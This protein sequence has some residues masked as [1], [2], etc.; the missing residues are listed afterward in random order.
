MGCDG[1]FENLSNKELFEAALATFEN[2]TPLTIYTPKPVFNTTYRASEV[3]TQMGIIVDSI[4]RSC[5]KTI[6]SDNLSLILICFPNFKKLHESISLESAAQKLKYTKNENIFTYSH[7]ES[8]KG[9]I[10]LPKK[11]GKSISIQINNPSLNLNNN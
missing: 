6:A 10:S 2:E 4:M 3:S 7:R 5:F 11:K 8:Y 9:S 1:I